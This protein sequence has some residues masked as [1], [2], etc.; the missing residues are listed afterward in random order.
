M[1]GGN[2][3]T[4]EKKI[5]DKLKDASSDEVL[6]AMGYTRV[7]EHTERLKLF[8]KMNDIYLWLKDGSWDYLYDAEGFARKLIEVLGLSGPE[9]DEQ[10][11]KCMRKLVQVN[12]MVYE[13]Y[14][15]ID[16]KFK[17]EGKSMHD[18]YKT[19]YK[20]RIM[21]RK[22]SLVGLNLDE[23]L[24]MVQELIK[25]HHIRTQGDLGIQGKIRFYYFRHC[26]G[27]IYGFDKYGE[28]L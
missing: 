17:R 2:T 4:L 18:L 19:S 16:T 14:I 5:I 22:E 3:M 24:D 9:A 10:I 8:I 7:Q 25:E 15:S 23:S 11:F 21:V 27:N 6:K 13:P 20:K 1:Y 26:D 28:R 12:E